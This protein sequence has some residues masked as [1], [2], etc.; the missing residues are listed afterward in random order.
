[1]C[2]STPAADHVGAA[3]VRARP[4]LPAALAIWWLA[5]VLLAPP[6]PVAA[7]TAG[8]RPPNVVWINCEDIGPTL[9]AYGDPLA[10]TPHLDRLAES[11]ITYL[12]ALANAPICSPARAALATGMHPVAFGGQHLR[13]E[14]ELPDPIRP[15][16]TLLRD[17]GWF[18]SNYGKTDTNFDPDG[19]FEMSRAVHD[20]R[21]IYVRHYMPHLPWIQFSR[22]T[23]DA[24]AS[25]AE[26]RR[27]RDAGEL[28]QVQARLWSA[29]KPV[30]ELYDLEN[31]PYEIR[32]LASDPAYAGR[33]ESMS[34]TLRQW[35][36][37][38]R[39]L[40][41]LAEAEAHLRAIDAGVTLYELAHDPEL[42]DI[43]AIMAAAEEASRGGSSERLLELLEDDDGAVR[44]WGA[45]GVQCQGATSPSLFRRLALV[46]SENPPATSIAAAEAMCHA[47]YPLS[48][49]GLLRA[50][51]GFIEPGDNWHEGQPWVKLQAARAMANIGED[52]RV[53]A[54]II[55]ADRAALESGD[56][57]TRI[58]RD[59]N[60]AAFTGWALEAVLVGLGEAR[61]DDF[62]RPEPEPPAEPGPAAVDDGGSR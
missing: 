17:A 42:Y 3:D 34:E 28:D 39:D 23:S 50:H 46:V 47:G 7:D 59:F 43:E 15:M 62:T 44:Y 61:W 1:M 25:F 14:I 33:V 57:P 27:A 55:A 30:E 22:I 9:A 60:Y 13:C 32:N 35:S 18:T 38:R 20:G 53:Y 51:F 11:G 2:R 21:F 16:P 36:V 26:L 52:A 56:H 31:D 19:M 40:G 37:E 48:A 58:Y 5:C 4:G 24:K 10:H 6:P 41:F 49:L 45:V 29:T 8:Q 12:N 54:R